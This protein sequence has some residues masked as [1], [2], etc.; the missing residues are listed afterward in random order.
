MRRPRRVSFPE[1][2]G[3]L[4]RGERPK[5]GLLHSCRFEGFGT[6]SYGEEAIVEQ[7]RVADFAPLEHGTI[8]QSPGHLAIFNEDRA[9]FADVAEGGI[10]RLWALS[11]RQTVVP[12]RGI[13]VVF[14]PDMAQLRGDVFMTASD[15]PELDE[16][17]SSRV[18]KIG[19]SIA[20]E[21]PGYRTRSFVIRAF[22]TDARGAALL[23]VYRLNGVEKRIA[24]FACVAACWDESE[25]LLVFDRASQAVANAMSWTPRVGA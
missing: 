5:S 25:A 7:F 14:D 11:D 3:A 21:D 18:I 16:S 20:R 15:H 17:A 23:A 2:L 24:G 13:S 1:T 6:E 8:F 12:E 19:R 9:L 22:G 4:T 10:S